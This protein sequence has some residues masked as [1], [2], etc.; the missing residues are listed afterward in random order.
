MSSPLQDEVTRLQA[1]ILHLLRR[2]PSSIHSASY[3]KSVDYK[4]KAV[5]A[6]QRAEAKSP[7]FAGLQQSCNELEQFE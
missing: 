2:V 5:L 7:K 4:K 6:R 1:R 3:G